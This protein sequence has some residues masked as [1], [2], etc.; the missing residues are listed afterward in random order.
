MSNGFD[1]HS[2]F[3]IHDIEILAVEISDDIKSNLYAA[4]ISDDKDT[5]SSF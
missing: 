2:S 5:Y 4:F 1:I 3:K